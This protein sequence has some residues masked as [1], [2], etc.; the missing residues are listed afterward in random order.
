MSK[1]YTNLA[2]VYH[3]IYQTLFDYDEEFKFYD[4][5]LIENSIESVLEVGCGTGNLAK[6]LVK[7]KYDYWGIDLFDEMLNIAKQTAPNAKFSQADVRA[8]DLQ[9]QFDCAIITGRSI[10]YLIENK[11]LL[12]AFNRINDS[13]KV[14]GILMF[15]AIDAKKMFMNF[16]DEKV[17]TLMVN[18]EV[19]DYQRTS[20]SRKN[21]SS[22]WT[23]DWESEYFKKD[24][25]G[26]YQK[27]GEDFATL[28]AFLKEELALFLNLSGFELMEVLPKKSYA[29]DDNFFIARKVL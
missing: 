27:I 18:F 1:L 3:E 28:R 25:D 11:G 13:L 16:D 21:M 8:F 14:G 20:K 10:S 9:C 5:H 15:D 22:G 19:N 7:A 26:N 23:W 6:R 24:I 12:E 17:D 4:K 29:W 2:N